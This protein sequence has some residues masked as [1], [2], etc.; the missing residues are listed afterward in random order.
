MPIDPSKM[1]PATK[2]TINLLLM[3]PSRIKD[4]VGIIPI[5]PPPIPPPPLL[6]KLF[7]KV[8]PLEELLPP[9]LLP[10]VFF[11]P[12]ENFLLLTPELL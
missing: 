12:P 11:V 2:E 8:D 10:R 9:D 4:Y 7:L 6:L 3:S 5:P 1:L